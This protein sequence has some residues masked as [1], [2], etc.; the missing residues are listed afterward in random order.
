[1]TISEHLTTFAGLEVVTVEQNA[2]FPARPGPVAWR[3]T[4]DYDGQ[5]SPDIAVASWLAR[6]PGAEQVT[7]L[8]LGVWPEPNEKHSPVQAL[9]D[10]APK[11]PALRH[12]FLGEMTYEECE[13]SWI[14]HSS[15]DPL[16]ATLGQQLETLV[17]RGSTGLTLS[18]FRSDSLRE[19][20]FESGG[21]PAE[22][23]EAVAASTLP[24]LDRLDIWLGTQHYERTAED[25]AL[26]ALL[27]GTAT[28]ALT[29][30][31]LMNSDRPREDLTVL[32]ASPLLPRLRSLDLSMG[33][34]GDECVPLLTSGAFAHLQRLNLN[35]H[36]LS[37]ASIGRL[38][39]ALPRTAV[40]ADEVGD[41]D[42]D[43]DE[44][45]PYAGRWVA[46]GE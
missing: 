7:A 3:F 32:A 19:L 22:V 43:D 17:V 45:T 44:D 20:A 37:E 9:A 21:M 41:N 27:A 1:M 8:L 2:P 4:A 31:G 35:H 16:L 15:L 5:E 42:G 33:V 24:R 39:T 11:L 34:L 12:L 38:R 10:A 14:N 28:P 29:R 40:F 36:Y 23:V 18:P 25:A 6:L 46:V 26:T 13:I 30:L